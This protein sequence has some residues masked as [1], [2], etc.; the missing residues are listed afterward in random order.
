M[1]MRRTGGETAVSREQAEADWV[2]AEVA[3]LHRHQPTSTIGILIPRRTQ[4]DLY[5]AALR[6]RQVARA[7]GGGGEPR[8]QTR[9]LPPPQPLQGHGPPLRRRGVGVRPPGPVVP[10][11]RRRAPRPQEGNGGRQVLVGD[12]PRLRAARGQ[13]VRRRDQALSR[14]LRPGGLP[15]HPPAG[16][17]NSSAGPQATA[18]RYDTYGVGNALEYLSL[19]RACGGLPAEEALALLEDRLEKAYTPP[20][21]AAA[22]SPV[23]LMT[24][25]K[26]KGLE[27]DHVFAV[28]L[29]YRPGRS[30]NQE[31]PPYHLLPLP[32]AA[33]ARTLCVAMERDARWKGQEP[34]PRPPLRHWKKREQAEVKRLFYVAVTRARLSLTLTGCGKRDEKAPLTAAAGSPL[35]LLLRAAC[36]DGRGPARIP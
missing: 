30:G 2:A 8:G 13:R 5:V 6:S 21:P 19:L 36:E 14:G 3:A 15:R 7:H 23:Q 9:G 31:R 34:G 1:K 10:G 26:A 28:Y 18:A 22:A 16:L 29:G 17:G 11:G 4:L 33:G 27:F 35:D 12:H 25:H 20:D 32:G 24:I